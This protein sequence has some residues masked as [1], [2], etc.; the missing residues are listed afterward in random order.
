M[1]VIRGI[2]TQDMCGMNDKKTYLGNDTSQLIV[3][4][5]S[6]MSTLP[7]KL[8]CA[9]TV[10]NMFACVSPELVKTKSKHD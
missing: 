9:A 8:D 2:S 4:S 5:L 1:G 10:G 3:V 6:A 7:T